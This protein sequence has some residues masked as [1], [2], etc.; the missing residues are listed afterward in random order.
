MRFSRI[1]CLVL[2]AAFFSLIG[3]PLGATERP[4][5]I[6]SSDIGGSDPDDFQS[7]V[8]YLVY[9]DAFDTEGLISSPPQAG[10]ARD[11]LT[12]IEAYARDFSSLRTGSRHYP[13][14][15][16]L[17]E[18]TRQ[19]AVV[20]QSGDRPDANTSAGAKWIIERARAKDARPLYVI[21]WGSITDVAQAVHADPSIKKKLRVYSIGSW[22]TRQ[23][24][25]ARDYLFTH[26]PDLWWIE[27]DTTFRGMYMG[28]LQQNDL[29]NRSFPAQHIQGHGH[30]GTLFMEKK[31]DIKM[32]DTPSVLYF[33]HGDPN[34]PES[35]HWGGAFVR[36]EPKTRP[37]YWHDN[38]AASLSF[39]NR[40]GAKTVSRWREAY[41]RD[42]QRRM[43]RAQ[44]S[45]L[46]FGPPRDIADGTVAG[47]SSMD[48][49]D[50]D[51]DGLADIVAIEGGKLAANRRTFAW[52]KAPAHVQE[53]W[54]RFAFNPAASLRSFLGA[55][56]L[57][58][59]DGDGDPDLVVSSDNHSG[60][61][62]E[63][64]LLVFINP[65][66]EGRATAAWS[67]H[68]VSQRPWPY[69]HINDM[70]IADMDSDGK[71]DIVVRSLQP[72]QIHILF[73]D[74]RNSYTRKSIDTGLAESEGLAVGDI[75]NN[76]QLDIAYTG[77]WLQSP[78]HPRTETYTQRPIDPRY[79]TVNQNTKETLGDIDGDG[80]LDIVIAPAEAFRKGGDHDLAWYRNPGTNYD[81]PWDK[82]VLKSQT[83]NHHTVQ[84]GDMDNDG[85]LDV[86]T[87]IPWKPQRI[88][89][90]LNL[91]NG[92]FAEG[93][94][95][96]S[97][98][99]LYSGLLADLDSDGDLDI[100]GQD[101][102]AR[103]S[104]PWVYEN[105]LRNPK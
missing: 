4:R 16:S 105:L 7:M 46:R 32:G 22:N 13:T 91:G 58:D 103:E 56:R 75:D 29:G 45:S 54:P 70:E 2:P 5:V 1:L 64:E 59:M 39:N 60:S 86:V 84:L 71:N 31:A 34:Q 63:A 83:N 66:P 8:H 17:R 96:S 69:H 40:P 35:E 51:G 78:A 11:I 24:P 89:I 79:H 12:C 73:N 101:T 95:P 82:T 41:L 53:P 3:T 80:R 30:L 23:D 99:G 104:R 55:A 21:V 93:V 74:S 90:F 57:A 42:W 85:D 27:N 72:N 92:S 50:I 18:V 25:R 87:G 100:V 9:A 52:F 97:D 38:P 14:P 28:G 44:T 48:A 19:G 20:P 98:K 6:V 102:Y 36:P 62:R 15:E 49:G 10:R 94:P 81:C 77:F 76:G 67:W 65:R 47:L 37:T 43:D 26:H 88:Q 33:L 68:K 61:K